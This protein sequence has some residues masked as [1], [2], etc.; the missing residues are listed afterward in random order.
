VAWVLA[1]AA[2]SVRQVNRR[3]PLVLSVAAIVALTSGCATFS[4]SSNIARVNDATLTSDDFQATLTELGAPSDQLLPAEAVRAQITTWIQ[5]QLAAGDSD[6]PGLSADEVAS[7]YDAGLDSGGTV[8]VNGIVVEDAGT[9]A[10][11]ADELVAGAEFVDLLESENLDPTLG[12]AGGDIG[13]ITNDQVTE[14][15]G[16]E[17]V[18]VAAGLDADDPFATAPLFDTQ[19]NEFAWVVL[20][21][22]PFAELNDTDAAAVTSTLDTANRLASAEIVVDPRYG[23][24]DATTGQVVALG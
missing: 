23:T 17:F 16:V 3:L 24:F 20:A 14:A 2:G 6:V 22:R 10:R 9:A 5:E 18:E 1:S 21:F 4:D 11:I 19:G 8:C 15:A 13:C 7:R 12:E